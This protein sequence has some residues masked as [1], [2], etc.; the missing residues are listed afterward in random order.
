[1]VTRTVT[2]NYFSSF[3][4]AIQPP[5]FLQLGRTESSPK[6]TSSGGVPG[7]TCHS[8]RISEW[9]AILLLRWSTLYMQASPLARVA[10]PMRML[11]RL[12]AHWLPV[13]VDGQLRAAGCTSD[14]LREV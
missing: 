14:A 7:I 13:G 12:R 5:N 3:F 4:L 10:E 11:M 8:K 9:V 1:M 2:R 6:G